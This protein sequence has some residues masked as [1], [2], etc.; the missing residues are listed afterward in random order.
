M[1]TLSW[2]AIIVVLALSA[3]CASHAQPQHALVPR[4]VID[5]NEAGALEALQHSNPVHYKRVRK[6]LDGV[7]RQKDAQVPGWIQA[8]F[9][10]RDVA[11]GPTVLT[12]HPPKRR[13]S[14]ALDTTRY[15]ATIVLTNVT[16]QIVPAR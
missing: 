8:N 12:S 2:I 11:Y 10:G 16:G 3:A 1:K 7:L 6:I 5:L 14:F 15:E 13:L 9:N 4:G